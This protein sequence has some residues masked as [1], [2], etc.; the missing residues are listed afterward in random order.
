MWFL[1]DNLLMF[2]HLQPP[3]TKSAKNFLAAEWTERKELSDDNIREAVYERLPEAYREKTKICFDRD[4]LDMNEKD[5]LNCICSRSAVIKFILL[6]L[7][8]KNR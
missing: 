6:D 2:E 3:C 4:H 7:V 1:M 5:F 8:T